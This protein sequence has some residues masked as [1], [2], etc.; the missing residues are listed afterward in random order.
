MSPVDKLRG[1]LAVAP[2]EQVVMLMKSNLQRG[3]GVPVK[4]GGGKKKKMAFSVAY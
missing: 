3:A 1:L 2:E 4:K